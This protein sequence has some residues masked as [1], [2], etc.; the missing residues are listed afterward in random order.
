MTGLEMARSNFRR[1]ATLLRESDG[2][3]FVLR[4]VRKVY[5]SGDAQV[6]DLQK[7]RRGLI[8]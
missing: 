4:D 2:I 3:V 7:W 5:P 8:Q 6:V 1:A